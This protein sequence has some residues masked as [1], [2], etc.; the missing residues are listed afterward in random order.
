MRDMPASHKQFLNRY[1]EIAKSYEA[2]GKAA[3]EWGPLDAKTRALVKLGIAVGKGHQG[4]VH[5]HTRRSLDAG[6]S[7]DEIRHTILLSVTTIGFP[8]MF[9]ALT[10]AE[11]VLN[12]E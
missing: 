10:W 9:A 6:A 5:S 8:G 4:A 7:P 12:A 1:P 2:L 3:Q 11:D